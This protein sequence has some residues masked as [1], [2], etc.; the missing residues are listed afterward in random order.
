MF[1][2]LFRLAF[3]F[4]TTVR[5]LLLLTTLLGMLLPLLTACTDKVSQAK[6]YH[7]GHLLYEVGGDHPFSGVVTGKAREGYRRQV[8][9]YEKQYKDGRLNGYSRYWYPNGKLESVVPYKH[10][11]L[12]GMVTRYYP[13]GT[14]KAKIHFVNGLRGGSKGEVFWG[15][16]GKLRKG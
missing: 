10:G 9:T 12:N 5:R 11:A 4:T 7:R 15:P 14:L 16:D 1:P 6:T 2:L 8:C 13:D 3:P